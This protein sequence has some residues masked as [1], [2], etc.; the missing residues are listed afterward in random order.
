[1]IDGLRGWIN[2]SSRRGQILETVQ[3]DGFRVELVGA[4]LGVA[5]LVGRPI[6]YVGYVKDPGSRS[7]GF[8]IGFLANVVLVIGGIGGA[9]YSLI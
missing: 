4:A 3:H 2:A 9:I 6:Y 7:T 8:V 1:M 5:F